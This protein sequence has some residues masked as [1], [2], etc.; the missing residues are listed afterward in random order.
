MKKNI[1]IFGKNGQVGSSLTQLFIEE[2]RF[3][4]GS[5]SSKDVDFLNLDS[6]A[7]FLEGQSTKP[8]FIINCAAYTNVDGA[9]DE[10]K[11]A[12]L[13][14]HKAVEIIANYCAKNNVKLVHYSTDYVFD[15]SGNEPFEADNTKNLNPLNH[16]GKSKLDGER[17]I[18]NSGC[19]YLILR[20]SWIWD[21]NPR[22]KNFYNTIKRLA[23][24]KEVLTII[25]DQIGSPTSAEF[26]A[27]N[28][29]E[30]IKNEEFSKEIRHL[31]N[32][33]YCSW[34]DFALNIIGEM[35]E[36]GELLKVKE[37]KPI[38]TSEYKT[39]AVRPLNSRLRP[40]I[41]TRK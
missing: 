24:E 13:T 35:Q 6:L 32:G 18:I 14:N 30:I 36:N 2:E 27:I 39:K 41:Q 4:V 21:K 3:N 38:K 33:K 19:E 22:F 28:T 11:L 40:S 10:K 17:A 25:D 23:K 7:K 16:Y 8:D 15:G 29:V 12:D 31:N 37:I 5:Y 1:T 20:I 34:Y 26:V 9:E